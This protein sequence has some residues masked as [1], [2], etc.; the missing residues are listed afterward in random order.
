M[1]TSSTDI[2]LTEKYLCGELSPE[3]S[4]LFQAQMLIDPERK[5]NT[6]FHRMVHSLIAQY[7]R[8]KLKAEI[9]QVHQKLFQ[10][11]AKA[12]F[13]QEVMNLFNF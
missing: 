7:H 2:F 1:K 8:K 4:V 6:Y 13:R 5:K 11:P 3:D 12:D 10:D 9:E